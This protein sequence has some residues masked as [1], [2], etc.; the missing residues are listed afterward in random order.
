MDL[1]KNQY[2]LFQTAYNFFNEKLFDNI[3]SDCLI[4]VARKGK[5]RGYFWAERFSNKI[6]G[7]I[8]HEIALNPEFFKEDSVDRV[9]S[10]LVH[11]MVHLWQ[12]DHGLKCPKT[13][14]HNKEWAK[15]MKEVGLIPSTTG[16][17]GGKETGA[18][19]S[20]YIEI[21][22]EFDV[23]CRELKK[24][25]DPFIIKA[26]EYTPKETPKRIFKFICPEGCEQVAYGKETLSIYCG[27][28][29]AEMII[30][31]GKEKD[32]EMDTSE[33]NN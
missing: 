26:I 8:V 31:T 2:T 1:T 30:E 23:A 21:D 27:D 3:L 20:H 28:C 15:K 5:A 18:R 25:I 14:Y 7:T 12:H 6:D 16:E 19:V 10:T 32:N 22:G 4:V 24:I 29:E 33:Y 13:A 9:L 11:E 17:E